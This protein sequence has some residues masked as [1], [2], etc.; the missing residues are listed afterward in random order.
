MDKFRENDYLLLNFV[1]YL[2]IS[3][4][5]KFQKPIFLKILIILKYKMMIK[6]KLLF[7][8]KYILQKK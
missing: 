5:L 8:I 6:I 4:N 7:A 1:A 3:I 2:F